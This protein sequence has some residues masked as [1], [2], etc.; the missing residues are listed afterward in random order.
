MTTGCAR[1][2][3]ANDRRAKL[4][5][6]FAS[7]AVALFLV[8]LAGTPCNVRAI[9]PPDESPLVVRVAAEE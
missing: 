5:V 3:R 9:D 2:E 8:T 1:R 6:L 4:L 7:A